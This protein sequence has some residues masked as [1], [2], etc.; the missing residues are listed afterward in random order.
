MRVLVTGA[1]GMI[2]SAVCDALLARG[3][4][5]VALSR[6]PTRAA[7]TNPTASWHPWDPARER[8]PAAALESIH[9]V[10][11]LVGES[12]DQRLT[13]DAKE[14]ILDSRARATKN[15]VDALISTQA[16]PRALVSQSAIGYYGDHG[17]AIVDE[18]T[19]PG[20]DFLAGVC[21]RWEGAAAPAAD[22]GIR[23]VTLRTAPVL[24]PDGGLLGRLLLPFRLGVGGP[25]AGGSWYMPWIHRDDEVGMILWALDTADAADTFNSCAPHP[26]TNREFSKALGRALRRPAIAPAPKLA[27]ALLLGREMA[28]AA[29]ASIRAVP[30]RALDAGYPFRFGEIEPALRDLVG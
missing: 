13:A 28:E 25:L 26:V 30:R 7:R 4:E 17:E 1:S 10:V 29:T 2:G 24:D 16:R 3:D 12:I 14:R 18:S 23:L 27:A 11:N 9:A 20:G 19:P 21:A 22:A 15:L 6:D 5:V 8:P